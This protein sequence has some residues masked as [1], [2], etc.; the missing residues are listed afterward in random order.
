[1]YIMA[2][3]SKYAKQWIVFLKERGFTN[4]EVVVNNKAWRS[5]VTTQ[6]V[7]R[8]HKHYVESSSI[9]RRQGSGRPTLRTGAL[10]QTIED[11]MQ[12][13]D[14]ATVVQICSYLLQR[15]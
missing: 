8:C 7:L 11:I 6:I 12:A 14:E 3:L 2:A 4:R 1:M 13:D 5:R 15:G 9:A 10:L